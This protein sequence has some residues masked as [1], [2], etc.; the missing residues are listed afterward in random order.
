MIRHQKV[1]LDA[2]LA[3]LYGVDTKAL[4]Q[5]VKRN[6]ARFPP[7][8][9]FRLT[10]TEFRTLRSQS[11]TSNERGGR[12]HR[13]Y[14][15]TEHGVAMLSSV[16]RSRRAIHVNIAIMRAFVRLRE[17][18]L[19]HERLAAR[20]AVLERKYDGQFAV[21][22]EAIRKLMTPP[23]SFLRRRIGFGG[24]GYAPRR[25]DRSVITI[26]CR[27]PKTVAA[28]GSGLLPWRRAI[29]LPRWDVRRQSVG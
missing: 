8:F 15:F 16:L 12:R 20:L 19:H 25:C 10:V 27:G 4:V 3:A 24:A 7:D 23:P 21:V 11:V 18:V 2:D 13:P 6:P 14:A 1:L 5:A 26:G 9:M 17:A 22:F 29:V 28:D